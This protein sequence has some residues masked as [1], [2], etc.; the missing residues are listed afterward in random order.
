MQ[1]HMWGHGSQYRQGSDSAR[2]LTRPG[3]S[4]STTSSQPP[5]RLPCYCWVE[6][7]KSNISHPRARALKDFRTL[8][9]H[10]RRKHCPRPF[11]CRRCGKTFAVRGDWQTH[12][13]NCGRLWFC[14]C[15]SNFKHKRS[16]KDHVCSFGDGHAPHKI[17]SMVVGDGNVMARLYDGD[18]GSCGHDNDEEEELSRSG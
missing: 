17:E 11:S 14:I 8:Q 13:K 1:M 5:M 16:L 4:S 15:G 3:P 6:G 18:H 2:G 12:Q 7:C 10:Y 9:I